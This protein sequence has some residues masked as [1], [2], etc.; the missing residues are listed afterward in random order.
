[1]EGMSLDK[2]FTIGGA[3]VTVALVTTVVAHPGSANVIRAVGAAF[4]SSLRAAMGK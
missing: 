1:M 4:S 2:I 3:I